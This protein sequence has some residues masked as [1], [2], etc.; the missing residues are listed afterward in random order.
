[1]TSDNGGYDNTNRGAMFRNKK[2]TTDK[3]P[4]HTGNLNVMG[5]EYWVSAWIKTDRNGSKYFSLAITPKQPQ[6]SNMHPA[7]RATTTTQD[8]IDKD[9]PF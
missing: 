5:I 8:D 3:Q 6:T 2:K 1:M 9:I 7:E 4:D